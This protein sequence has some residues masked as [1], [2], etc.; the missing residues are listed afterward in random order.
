MENTYGV[1]VLDQTLVVAA[2][3]NQEKNAG[4]VLKTVDPFPPLAL[5]S[6][7]VDHK[8]LVVAEVKGCLSDTDCTS[9]WEDYVLL[10]RLV[11]RIE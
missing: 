2:Q 9:S 4:D 8:H 1:L 6:A 10:D 7:D 5:L 3:A 11:I